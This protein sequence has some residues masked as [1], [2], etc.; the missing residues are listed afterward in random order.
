MPELPE[1]HYYSYIIN[2]SCKD[3]VFTGFTDYTNKF[4]LPFK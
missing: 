1:I 2:K 3:R 4:S